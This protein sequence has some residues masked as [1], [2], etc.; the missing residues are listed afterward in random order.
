MNQRQ[1]NFILNKLIPFI[2]RE[3]GR[4]FG[5]DTWITTALDP[6]ESYFADGVERA[7]PVC[8]TIPCIVGS[9]TILKKLGEHGG[10]TQNLA[11]ILGL[12]FNQACALFFEWDRI[13][14]AKTPYG[15]A[16]VAVRLLKE[17]VRT[18]GACL[19]PPN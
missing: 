3:H 16:Q 8:G 7:V 14:R 12:D 2:S 1:K 19:N 11:K 10:T 5:M 4:G 6:S 13:K 15:K 18:E 17:V 9:I